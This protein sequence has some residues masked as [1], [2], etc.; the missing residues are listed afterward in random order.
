[1]LTMS[2]KL[3]I[4]PKNYKR[5]KIHPSKNKVPIEKNNWAYNYGKVDI[6]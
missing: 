2:H 3:L 1:M 6:N 4:N 5:G